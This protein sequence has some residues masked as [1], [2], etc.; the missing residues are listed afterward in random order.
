MASG[1]INNLAFKEQ[2][3]DKNRHS[4]SGNKLESKDIKS[5]F[6]KESLAKSLQKI[7]LSNSKQKNVQKE[8]PS[9]RKNHKRAVTFTQ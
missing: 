6:I 7:Q 8:Q 5:S 4:F 9:Y 2:E 3:G 1:K